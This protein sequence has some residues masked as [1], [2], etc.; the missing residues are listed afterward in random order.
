MQP[1]GSGALRAVRSAGWQPAW[2]RLRY[3]APMPE[4]LRYEI[5]ISSPVPPV[6]AGDDLQIRTVAQGDL[7][8]LARLMLDAYVGTIDYEGETLEQA[9]ERAGTKMGNAGADAAMT[10]MEMTNVMEQ[11]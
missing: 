4:K 3:A 8:G 10:A 9:V 5:D 1:P 6:E 2:C 7:A 11:I